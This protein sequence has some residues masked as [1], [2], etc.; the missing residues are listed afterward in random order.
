MKKII[1]LIVISA[2]VIITTI[3]WMTA[4]KSAFKT[5]EIIQFGIIF[6]IVAFA[7]FLGYKRINSDRKG[8]PQEDE[9]S[10]K[11]LT[12]TSSV[13]YYISLYLWLVIMYISNKTSLAT[14][15]LIGAGILGMAC[16]FAISWIIIYIRGIRNE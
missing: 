8:E 16:I 3:V 1:I 9:L 6:L 13:S 10:K 5:G 15:T 7:V 4:S 12:K 2:L 14:H 11:I